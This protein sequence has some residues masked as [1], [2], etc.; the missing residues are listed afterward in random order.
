M[1][2]SIRKMMLKDLNEVY[3]IEEES[4][5]HPWDKLEFVK[6]LK[7]N[8]FAHYFVCLMDN[9]IMGFLGMWIVFEEAHITNIAIS[10]PYRK[11]GI[12][13]TCIDFA[14][15]FAK[16]KGAQRIILEVRKSNK[17]AIDLYLKKGFNYA[18]I[19]KN[20]Y[21]DN[22]EDAFEMIKEID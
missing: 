16:S 21:L 18:S 15:S 13:S 3:K 4:Y 9:K 5:T 22:F 2:L 20:Y 6:E 19:K 17:E 12:G 7:G 10:H 8:K 11:R 14:E 1:N